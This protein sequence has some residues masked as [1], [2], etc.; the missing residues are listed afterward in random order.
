MIDRDV[1]KHRNH[2]TLVM[3]TA[4]AIVS[5]Y[6]SWGTWISPPTAKYTTVPFHAQPIKVSGIKPL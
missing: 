1:S 3:Y 5:T 2:M 4:I 6:V